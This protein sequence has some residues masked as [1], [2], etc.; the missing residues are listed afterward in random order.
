MKFLKTYCTILLL[1]FSAVIYS[2]EIKPGKPN[3]LDNIYSPDKTSSKPILNAQSSGI[4]SKSN[5]MKFNFGLLAR[6]SF[7]MHY[8]RKFNDVVSLVGGL[9]Y[10]YNK[11]KIQSFAADG[12]LFIV[13]NSKSTISLGQIITNSVYD[14]GPN[15]FASAAIK[16]SYDGLFTSWNDEEER[17]N[18]VQLEWRRSSVNMNLTDINRYNEQIG[19][20]NDLTIKSTCYLLNWGYQFT[21][22]KNVITSHEFS[23]G[24]GIRKTNYNVFTSTVAYDPFGQSYT[25]HQKTSGTETATS[26]MVTLG[27]ILG[28]GF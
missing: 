11:D 22:G 21:A 3:E 12:D 18:F 20:G 2:Q 25:V 19:Y 9:G 26:P 23:L 5:F 4:P 1:F 28:F 16:L 24:F 27:Y 17:R 14:S 8:E 15:L 13:D 10:N 7:A 6:S